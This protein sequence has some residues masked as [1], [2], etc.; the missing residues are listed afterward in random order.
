MEDDIGA[1]TLA[2]VGRRLDLS[3]HRLDDD[4]V[5]PE[6]VATERV[7]AD[8]RLEDLDLVLG[9]LRDRVAHL[10]GELAAVVGRLE[11]SPL[12]LALAENRAGAAV[13]AVLDGI[14]DE[15]ERGAI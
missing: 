14:F 15:R 12:D 10:L 6:L 4:A 2:A 11:I 7:V 1:G 8:R 3:L 9:G 5:I 13:D